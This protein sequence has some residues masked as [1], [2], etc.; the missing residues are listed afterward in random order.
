MSRRIPGN[1]SWRI[2][3][4]FV[5]L[6]VALYP[7]GVWLLLRFQSASPLMLSVGLAT[8][9]ACLVCGRKLDTLG[10]RWGNWTYH[11]QSYLIPLAYV[12]VAYAA[13]WSL[14]FGGWYATGFVETL[15]EGYMLESWSDASII[16]LRFVLTGTVSFVLLL[17]GVLGEELGWRGLLVPALSKHFRFTYVALVSGLLWSMWH[18][19]LM[20]LGFY[21][22]AETPMAFQLATFTV[23]LVSMSVVMAYIRYKTNSLWPAVIF[24]M[25]H[26]AFLQKFFSPI[27]EENTLTV[28]FADEFGLAVPLVAA[29]FALVYWR[30]GLRE[31]G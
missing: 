3:A 13:I 25:S 27:T 6:L 1:S 5:L 10:W 8:V 23:C 19:P 29:C 28:W 16:A 18:W 4:V 20:F 31:F 30:K 24:H 21:G 7:L 17:P 2:I 14:A 26:N 9:G 12:A 15:R 11:Y 22:N